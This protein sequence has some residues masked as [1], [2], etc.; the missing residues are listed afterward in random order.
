VGLREDWEGLAGRID[1]LQDAA[2]LYF[3]SLPSVGLDQ[4]GSSSYH[5]I[6][7]A[8]AVLSDLGAFS[9]SYQH[10][11]PSHAKEVI[12]KFLQVTSDLNS[13]TV[14]GIPGVQGLMLALSVFRTEFDRL[15]R[16]APT[17]AKSLIIR[18]FS[19]LQRLIVANKS[20]RQIWESAFK[21]GEPS[22]EKLGATHLLM[23]GIWA[24]KASA[25]GER[26][27]LVLGNRFYIT[28]EIEASAEALVLTEWKRA[29]SKN[30]VTGK[31][32]EALVQMRRYS[33]SILAGF[34]LANDRYIILVSKDFL[35]GLSNILEG[36]VTYH[37]V[38]I[39][40]S[41]SVPSNLARKG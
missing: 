16:D 23:H 7:A 20:E 21:E 4:Y 8:R 10:I 11:L 14:T 1:G 15:I 3:E 9:E 35:E 13:P 33:E 29:P 18:A 39:A 32:D 37:C 12:D 28:P 27:D 36:N 19:H 26:T 22:C 38:N 34:E 40:V 25:A 41:P 17:R 24:F 5:L 31:I 6:P 30:L 2:R